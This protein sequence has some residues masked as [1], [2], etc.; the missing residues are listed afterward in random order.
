VDCNNL[1]GYAQSQF[2]PNDEMQWLT[3]AEVADLERIAKEKG[4]EFQDL[5]FPWHTEKRPIKYI[6]EV[7]LEYPQNYHIR[8]NDYPMAPE[9]MNIQAA[10]LSE[11]QIKLLRQYYPGVNSDKHFSR[12]LICSLLP[13][14]HYVVFSENLWFYL[15]RG[16]RLV[17]V[18]FILSNF[19]TLCFFFQ[20]HRGVKFFCEKLVK[21][22]IEKNIELRTEAR[23]VGDEACADAAKLRNNATYGK[24]VENVEKRSDIRLCT[25]EKKA[26]KLGEKPH[27]IRFQIFDDNLIGLEMRKLKVLINKPFHVCFT[28]IIC[29][30]TL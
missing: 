27:C 12:K 21:D 18:F 4:R 2:L 8:D 16:M 15:D 1:Y 19:Y 20:I 9:L 5:Y 26:R 23:A 29:Y 11:K 22:Y 17:K 30:Y 13:K 3:Q 7:D 14:K 25:D 28:F 6:L 24:M 10:N